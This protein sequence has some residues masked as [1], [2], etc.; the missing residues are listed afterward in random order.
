MQHLYHTVVGHILWGV[1]NCTLILSD[2]N[3]WHSNSCNQWHL[4]VPWI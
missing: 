1:F 2:T 3:L 4:I